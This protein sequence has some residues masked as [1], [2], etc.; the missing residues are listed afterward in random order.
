LRSQFESQPFELH[1]PA[2]PAAVRACLARQWQIGEEQP[3]AGQE[4]KLPYDR[5]I[6]L[7]SECHSEN[8]QW[9]F[10]GERAAIEDLCDLLEQVPTRF[11]LPPTG[12]KPRG[13]VLL[14]RRGHPS[15]IRLE[16]APQRRIDLDLISGPADFLTQLAAD[17]REQIPPTGAD[18]QF[19]VP[20]AGR[21]KWTLHLHARA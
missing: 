14:A 9:H 11:P 20:L 19:D 8:Y 16:H 18:S 1:E 12:A 5:A 7:Y 13:S 15:Y 21:E 2:S 4:G 6:D 10:D 3:L 17:I